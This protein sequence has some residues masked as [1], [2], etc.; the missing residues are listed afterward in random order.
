MAN[1]LDKK[2]L[3]HIPSGAGIRYERDE[4]AYLPKRLRFDI[5]WKS[6]SEGRFRQTK[7][8]R[9]PLDAP[10]P[11]I[12][13]S[14]S[15][16]YHPTECRFLTVREAALCQSFPMNFVFK[17]SVTA[18]FRQIGNAV[19]PL[20]AKYLGEEIKNIDFSQANS[21]KA[22]KTSELAKAAFSYREKRQ[23]A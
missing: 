9:L 5:D 20:L 8:Q 21:K 13:T 11:T 16:Y 7:L 2:R 19:P 12:L 22:L 10:A 15:M 6:I 3:K 1:E 23:Y 14:R 17:G 4:Q 18:Q